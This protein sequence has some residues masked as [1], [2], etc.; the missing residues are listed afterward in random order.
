MDMGSRAYVATLVRQAEKR[1]L[2]SV[3]GWFKSQKQ[4]MWKLEYY[5]ERR[6]KRLGLVDELG[7][8][9]YEEKALGR[10]QVDG[11]GSKR[12]LL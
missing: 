5:Q 2:E 3:S 11:Y 1:A 10:E 7:R 8:S 9:T 12:T 6:L 4:G